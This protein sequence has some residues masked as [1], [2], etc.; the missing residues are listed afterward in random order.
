MV[1]AAAEEAAFRGI[2]QG[3]VGEAIGARAALLVQAVAFG[4]LHIQG[5]PSG[6][7]GV[8]LAA[9]YGLA[10][11]A[12]RNHTGGLLAPWLAHVAADVVI[13]SVLLF[14]LFS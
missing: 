14:V 10:I 8:L 7:T 9:T 6:L 11:G 4:L 5:F 1:N 12:L 13:A 3:A 2:V